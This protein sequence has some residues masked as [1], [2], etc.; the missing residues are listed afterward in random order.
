MCER[1]AAWLAGRLRPTSQAL[2]VGRVQPAW[3]DRL[4]DG[5]LDLTTAYPHLSAD[6][7]LRYPTTGDR[8]HFESII[9]ERHRLL[10]A[11]VL[12]ASAVGDPHSTDR[13]VEGVWA[14]AE[15]TSWCWPAHDDAPSRGEKLPDPSRP[16]LDLGAG[17]VAA[18]LAWTDHLVGSAIE[19]RAQGIRSRIR[20]E[21]DRRVLQPFLERDDWH[22]LGLDGKVHNW[23]AW[24]AGNVLTATLALVDDPVRR[25][26]LVT[27]A[28]ECLD[29]FVESLPADGAIDEGYGYW[30]NGA[31]RAI[32]AFS[33]LESATEGAARQ[34]RQVPQLRATISFPAAMHLGGA[35]WVNVADGSARPDT[36]LAWP[37][38]FRAA[39]ALGDNHARSLALSRRTGRATSEVRRLGRLV[40]ELADEPW[41][42]SPPTQAAPAT[43]TWLGSVELLVAREH[44][45]FC[46]LTL[47]AKGGHNDENHNHNDVGSFIVALDSTPVVVDLGRPS[48]DAR[49]FSSER[50]SI[51]TLQ[52]NWHNVPLIQGRQQQAGRHFAATDVD[53][54]LGATHAALSLDIAGAYEVEDSTW[55]R[56][57]TLDRA[58]SR[59]TCTDQWELGGP[60]SAPSTAVLVVAGTPRVVSDREVVITP[61]GGGASRLRVKSD[62]PLSVEPRSVEDPILTRVWGTTVFRI[63]IDL[64][65]A[66]TGD[67]S[68]WFEAVEKEG[69]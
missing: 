2:P 15:Q 57:M 24:I 16:F 59:I 33:L 10:S 6:D 45:D 7:W 8:A 58:T 13:V 50:Y 11:A 5:A 67:A 30:W 49:T 35:W 23:L 62:A 60:A 34:W 12:T 40:L 41:W 27:R 28:L 25:T 65:H 51:W 52:S 39:E 46:G 47:V 68:V 4:P 69:P 22:W 14:F 66:R 17:E 19:A 48:Y 42:T 9:A 63:E 53:V 56:T 44:E 36:D 32:E 43:Q 20:Q 64:S 55:R 18:Q 21:V 54:T 38:L 37:S 3:L 31:C 26:R 1:D 61:V 29:R